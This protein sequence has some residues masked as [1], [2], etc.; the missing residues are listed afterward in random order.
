MTKPAFIP[1]I[2]PA[3]PTPESLLRELLPELDK[4][5]A[6]VA[7]LKVMIDE[8]GRRYIAEKYPTAREFVR[9]SEERLRRELGI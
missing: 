1:R 5:E 7:R 2:V 9:P 4:A 3:A 6:V 8:Q